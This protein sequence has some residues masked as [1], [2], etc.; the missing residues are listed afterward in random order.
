MLKQLPG[1]SYLDYVRRPSSSSVR[2]RNCYRTRMPLIC[3]F[4]CLCLLLIIPAA[5]DPHRHLQTTGSRT[6]WTAG[7]A[8]PRIHFS[9][10]RITAFILLSPLLPAVFRFLENYQLF[11]ADKQV[12][13]TQSYP[14]NHHQAWAVTAA[15][16]SRLRQKEFKVWKT[17]WDWVSWHYHTYT[18]QLITPLTWILLFSEINDNFPVFVSLLPHFIAHPDFVLHHY[19]KTYP[20]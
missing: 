4:V 1:C 7:I 17:C 20:K 5:Y 9:S 11:L 14:N 13:L 2:C 18:A 10:C 12:L 16:F 6:V 15:D 8:S 3:S 19:I